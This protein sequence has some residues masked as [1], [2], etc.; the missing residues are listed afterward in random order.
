MQSIRGDRLLLVRVG[1]I[2]VVG[3]VLLLLLVLLLRAIV[4]LRIRLVVV[5]LRS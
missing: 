3:R 5:G 2:S 1:E 4:S